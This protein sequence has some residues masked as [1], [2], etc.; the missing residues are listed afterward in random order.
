MIL[1]ATHLPAEMS[2]INILCQEIPDKTVDESMFD[3]LIFYT[4]RPGIVN[5]DLSSSTPCVLASHSRQ[6]GYEIHLRS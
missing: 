4:I 3:R 2:Y 6:K 5:S 1:N